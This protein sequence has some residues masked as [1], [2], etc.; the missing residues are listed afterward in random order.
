[1][2]RSHRLFTAL[3]AILLALTLIPFAAPAVTENT[4]ESA[5]EISLPEFT[6]NADPA[7][8][9]PEDEEKEE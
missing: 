4:M 7:A 2:F 6:E 8:E 3:A 5:P 1:M 9:A